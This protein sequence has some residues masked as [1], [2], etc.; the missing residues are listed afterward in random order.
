MKIDSTHE[1]P[2]VLESADE[3]LPESS[4]FTGGQKA[5]LTTATHVATHLLPIRN[6]RSTI[7]S[8][9][10]FVVVVVTVLNVFSKCFVLLHQAMKNE[11]Q[12]SAQLQGL[13]DQFS[14][15]KSSLQDHVGH[16]EIMRE[17]VIV[18]SFAFHCD[19]DDI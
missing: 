14:L 19:D 9:R 13:R 7:I 12:L 1:S 2:L 17:E 4:T 18:T 5:I 3:Q 8:A 15:R 11:E 6:G 16:L 10:K